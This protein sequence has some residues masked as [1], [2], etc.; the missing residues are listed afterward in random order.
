LTVEAFQ[1]DI[2]IEP[3]K[4]RKSHFAYE[5]TAGEG[6]KN[7]SIPF[8]AY[9]MKRVLENDAAILNNQTAF[10]GVGIDAFP[11]FDAGKAYVKGERMKIFHKGEVQYFTALVATVAGETPETAKVKWSNSNALA[12]CTGLGTRLK[13][14][15][16]QGEIKKVISSGGLSPYDLFKKLFRSHTDARK[17]VGVSIYVQTGAYEELL[18]D[19]EN[20]VGKYT[21]NDG[22][23]RMY[24][25]NTGRKG[26]IVPATWMSGSSMAFSGPVDNFEMGTDLLSDLNQVNIIPDVYQL[27]M[28]IV[29]VLGFNFQDPEEVV[30]TD[31]D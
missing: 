30:I 13:T 21:E 12:I 29:G 6:S 31:Q 5:R 10:F 3:A 20:K 1:R 18:D 8:E 28:G 27:K 25:S 17:A 4:Y 9:T 16:S 14:A 23:G 26:L 19:F 2:L 11:A 7:K 15:R 22:S 24:L